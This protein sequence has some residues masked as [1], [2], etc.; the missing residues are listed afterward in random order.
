MTRILLSIVVIVAS[1][2]ARAEV[3]PHALVVHVPPTSSPIGAPIELEAMIDS[4]FAEALSVR[5]R[6]IGDPAWH[7]TRFERSSAGGWYAELPAAAPPGVEYYIHGT[8]SSGV[9]VDHFASQAAPHVVHVDPSLFDRLE[10]LDRARLRGRTEEVSLDVDAHQFTN[11]HGL[12]DH[13]TRG[14]L[15]Y[16]HRMLREL[17]EVGFGFG[18]IEGRTPDGSGADA[19]MLLHGLRYGF[20]QVRLRLHP[21]VFVDARVGLGVSEDGFQGQVRGDVILGK[22]WRSCVTIGGELLGGLGPTAWARLQ[23]DTAP[24]LLMG[25]AVYYTELPDAALSAQYIVY[26]VAYPLGRG[27]AVLRAQISYGSRNGPAAFGGGLG[28]SLSF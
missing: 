4:P 6:E 27:A 17:H 18:S 3:A 13:Y 28:T 2:V 26:D 11:R 9:E 20:G 10:V 16:T 23:W 25:A 8:D 14:E 22:P 5:W 21:S 24:P 1:H 19:S 12:T 7:D 15:V